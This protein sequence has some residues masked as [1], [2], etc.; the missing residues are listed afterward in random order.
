MSVRL[1]THELVTSRK[2]QTSVLL[3]SHVGKLPGNT[4]RQY[5]WPLMRGKLPGNTR[6]Q[7]YWPLMIRA[8]TWVLNPPSQGRDVGSDSTLLAALGGVGVLL[9]QYQTYPEGVLLLQYQTYPV[10]VLSLQYQSYPVGVLLLQ[11]QT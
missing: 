7:Y 6:R 8:G 3:A 4:R 11:Y 10:G 5:Y 2:H 9:L 1:A